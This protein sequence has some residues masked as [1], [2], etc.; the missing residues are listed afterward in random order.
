MAILDGDITCLHI[1]KEFRT[2]DR[3]LHL[4]SDTLLQLAI[5]T[6][7]GKQKQTGLL[8]SKTCNLAGKESLFPESMGHYVKC[9]PDVY[10]APLITNFIR[11]RNQNS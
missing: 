1:Y 2:W 8:S 7:S 5:Y 6:C 4:R 3:R 9:Y 11:Q 10:T